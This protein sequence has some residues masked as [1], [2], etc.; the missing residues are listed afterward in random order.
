M[1]SIEHWAAQRQAQGARRVGAGIAWLD[2]V[3]ERAFDRFS[4]EG[5]PG[6]RKEGWRHTSL[7]SLQQQAFAAGTAVEGAGVRACLE[8]VMTQDEGH[9]L[10][11]VDG[12][13]EPRLSCVGTP[14]AGARVMAVSQALQDHGDDVQAV[15]GDET[16]GAS[17]AALN[18]AMGGDGGFVSLQP[19]V[20]LEQPVHLVFISATPGGWAFP[21]SLIVAQAGA[22]ASVIEHYLTADGQ[23]DTGTLTNAVTRCALDAD[24]RVT[25]MKL[26]LENEQAFH[27]AAIQ[28]SQARG[29]TFNSHSLS[30]GARLARNDIGTVFA[31]EHCETLFNGLYHVDGRRHVDHT[32]L[33]HHAQ[34]QGTSR[35]FYRG[36]LDNGSRGVFGG[37]ILVDP[38]ADGTDA[39]QRSDSLLLSRM[40]RADAR[41]ELEIYADDVKCAHGATVGQLD[42]DAL[43]YLRTRGFDAVRARDVL[44]CAF[45]AQAI[46]RI[47]IPRLR[48]RVAAL[49]QARLPAGGLLGEWA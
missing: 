32:T 37:R 4:T 26:Q 22:Q 28:A 34:P 10:V 42:E 15:F 23:F 3:R 46:A 1:S 25:H 17:P 29:S 5:W 44:T 13:H 36:I 21:R 45:A 7:A 49:V 39:E 2:A 8:R 16:Q 24:A 11:F 40:A 33:I 12:R 20:V 9:W 31:G 14:P 6:P 38:G 30:F 27:L 48:E 19:G 35:E 43:F 47:D 18:L 41:P